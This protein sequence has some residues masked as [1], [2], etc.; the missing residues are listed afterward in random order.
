MWSL[1][2]LEIEDEANTVRG[3]AEVL[4]PLKIV[5]D[6]VVLT[7]TG[8]LLG[9]WQVH[10]ILLFLMIPFYFILHLQDF[11]DDLKSYWSLMTHCAILFLW[12]LE[13]P[14][15]QLQLFHELVSHLN[16]KLQGFE[17]VSCIYLDNYFK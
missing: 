3:I 15:N 9:C 6:R 2:F 10:L 12:K 8:V 7:S 4:C 1:L 11:L 14:S 13:T 17:V 16:N 5:L